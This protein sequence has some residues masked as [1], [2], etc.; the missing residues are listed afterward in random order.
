MNVDVPQSTSQSRASN[1]N[2]RHAA[3]KVQECT[4]PVDI[5]LVSDDGEQ[6]GAHKFNLSQYS[7][8]FPPFI[9][10]E[11][12]KAEET[13]MET[14]EKVP[15]P[16]RR[17]PLELLLQYMH[18]ARQPDLENVAFGVLAELSEA[19]EKYVVYSAMTICHLF[20]ERNVD[21]HPLEVFLYAQKHGYTKLA[22]KAAPL[23]LKFSAEEMY[24][25]VKKSGVMETFIKWFRYRE[26]FMNARK[27]I[28]RIPPVVLHS[29]GFPECSQ[30]GSFQRDV[31]IQAGTDYTSILRFGEI[32]ESLLSSGN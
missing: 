11:G 26:H 17:Q 32:V 24:A 13:A 20:M 10:E 27:S 28:F 15:L 23:T 31:L 25:Q 7:D 14:L 29:G 2:A 30:W 1:T 8:G 19:S 3:C 16:E 21:T 9:A 22:D 4:L 5:I 18:H 6:F 12:T